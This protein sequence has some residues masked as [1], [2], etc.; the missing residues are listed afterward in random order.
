MRYVELAL[1]ASGGL[2][3]SVFLATQV[4]AICISHAL[5]WQVKAAEVVTNSQPVSYQQVDFSLWGKNRIQAYLASLSMK[6]GDPLAVLSIP[7]ISITA[8]VYEG[9]DSLT[10]DR[11]LGH[12]AGTDVPGGTHNIAIAGHRDGFFRGLKDI[13]P[14][15]EIDALWGNK[16]EIYVVESTSIV[17]PTDMSVLNPGPQS[18]L[19]L[20]TCYPFYFVGDAPSRFIVRASLKNRIV[21]PITGTTDTHAK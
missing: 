17:D 8:P 10:L 1:I 14:G 2:M 21:L 7:R 3:L 15:D 18:A 19:T 4:Y 11:G 9:T 6:F 5:L 20:I 12:V 16:K 13:R